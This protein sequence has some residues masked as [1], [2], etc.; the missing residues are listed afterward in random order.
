MRT[1]RTFFSPKKQ[2][3]TVPWKHQDQQFTFR[4]VNVQQYAPCIP[5][6]A[7]GGESVSVS[8]VFVGCWFLLLRV[9]DYG[10]SP[11][12]LNKAKNRCLLAVFQMVL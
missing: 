11:A 6:G 10:L 4:T 7:T 3:V 12:G 2:N 5:F 8:E 1:V 9:G